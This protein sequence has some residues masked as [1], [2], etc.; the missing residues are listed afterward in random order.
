MQEEFNSMPL[1]PLQG[2]VLFPGMNLPLYIFEDRYKNMIQ[3]CLKNNKLFGVVLAKGNMCAEIG[4]IAE[5]IDAEKLD[6]GKMNVLAEGKK[7]FKIIDLT[8]EEPYYEANVKSYEDKEIEID[9]KLKKSLKDVKELSTKALNLFDRISEEDLSLKFKLPQ[10]PQ[11][12]L[13]LIAANLTCT[14]EVKQ[15]ILET[16]S[17]KERTKKILSLLKEEIKRLE[18]ILENKETSSTVVKNGKLQIS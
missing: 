12:L 8:S 9:D 10:N 11:E 3:K 4:T 2:V 18:V 5:I 13:F 14:F 1:F 15:Y 16:R 17:I 7:R 6:D